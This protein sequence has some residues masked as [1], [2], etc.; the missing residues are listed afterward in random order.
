MI[1]IDEEIY[2]VGHVEIKL[3]AAGNRIGIAKSPGRAL[4][5][6]ERRCRRTGIRRR[7]IPGAGRGPA[8]LDRT[9]VFPAARLPPCSWTRDPQPRPVADVAQFCRPFCADV[10]AALAEPRC[11][12]QRVAQTGL[13]RPSANTPGIASAGIL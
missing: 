10:V 12:N 5:E 1:V 13:L 7:L 11:V 9:A 6:P 4:F 3:I 2:V 8:T